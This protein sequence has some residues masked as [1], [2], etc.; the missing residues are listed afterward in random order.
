MFG[1]GKAERER[2]LGTVAKRLG[3][4]LKK[5]DFKCF[6]NNILWVLADFCTVSPK[7]KAL[8]D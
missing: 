6:Q 1:E 5:P 8:F 3:N 7:L 2:G 4:Y